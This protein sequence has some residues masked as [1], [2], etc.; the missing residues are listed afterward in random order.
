[1]T[2]SATEAVLEARGLTVVRAG[3]D[4]PVAVLDG[5]HFVLPSK[6][7]VEV[8]GPSG[9]G[10]T[11][12]LLALARLLPG[13]VGDLFL[14]GRPALAIAPQRWRAKVALLPQRPALIAG[15]LAENLRLPWSLKVR[16]ESQPPS[17]SELRAA[18]ESVG[19]GALAL[20]RDVARLSVGQAARVALERVMLTRPKVLL[21]DEPDASLDDISA[22]EVAR[23]T[24]AFVAG[25]GS[26]VRVSHVRNDAQTRV[27]YQLLDGKLEVTNRATAI[28]REV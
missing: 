19:L 27:C 12:F 25:G 4:G 23:A 20:E 13:T 17:D 10:K 14:E 2:E 16:A 24:S 9:T 11:T 26:V 6:A 1:M 15:T 18:L 22:A 21:L 28:P 7:L 3:D 8:T 5:V